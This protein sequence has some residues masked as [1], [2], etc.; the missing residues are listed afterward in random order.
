M[1]LMIVAT[2]QAGHAPEDRVCKLPYTIPV[3]LIPV[4]KPAYKTQGPLTSFPL[5]LLHYQAD[6]F[7]PILFSVMLV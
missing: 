4:Y 7:N 2:F 3:Q 5:S 6:R 1:L